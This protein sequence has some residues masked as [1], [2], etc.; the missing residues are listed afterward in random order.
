MSPPAAAAFPR[1]CGAAEVLGRPAS[2]IWSA[3]ALGRIIGGMYDED[4]G[5]PDEL[6]L[7]AL[8]GVENGGAEGPDGA[9]EAGDA[10]GDAAAPMAPDGGAAGQRLVLSAGQRQAAV[11]SG[12]PPAQ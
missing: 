12:M 3:E 1:P 2:G 10:G 8:T 6:M 5:L 7:E 9:A 4:G 11:A